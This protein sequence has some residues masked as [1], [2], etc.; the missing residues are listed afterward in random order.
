M[1]ADMRKG[2]P[3]HM[4]LD[5]TTSDFIR[6]IDGRYKKYADEGGGTVVRLKKA[7]YGCVESAGLWYDDLKTT[8]S[9]LGYVRN[10]D[11]ISACTTESGQMDHSA[12]QQCM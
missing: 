2:V 4:Q 6:D 8:M 10:T 1:N 11:A 3:V 5:R 9:S 7:L 12:L